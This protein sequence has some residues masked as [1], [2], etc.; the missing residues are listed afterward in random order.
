MGVLSEVYK[1]NR[2]TPEDLP[3]FEGKLFYEGDRGRSFVVRYAALLFLSTL[4]ASNGIINDSTATVIGAMIIAPL[5]T[6]IM[7]TAAAMVMGNMP[8]VARSLVLVASGVALVISVSWIIG[9]INFV[10][11]RLDTTS[12]NS[13]VVDRILPQ[14]T[15][16]VIALA[17]GIAGAFAISRR[18]VADSLPGV[19]I[20]ISLV[21]PLCVVGIMLSASDFSAAWGAMLLFLTNFLSILLAGGGFLAFLGLAGAATDKLTNTARRNAFIMVAL[22][23][24]LVFIPLAATSIQVVSESITE[25]QT[26]EAASAW[27]EGSGYGLFGVE[28]HGDEVTIIIVGQ[29]DLPPMSNLVSALEEI[30]RRNMFLNLQIVP[31]QEQRLEVVPG[32]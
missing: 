22:A 29:G 27:L 20:S 12:Q 26:T 16:L 17:S 28:V 8:R 9:E 14:A 2:F 13:Q 6:P 30:S 7:A 1:Y 15:D 19:A 3:E 5:M 21:P 11:L 32:E 18:D 24:I 23:V 25:F 4:I 10:G 31:V